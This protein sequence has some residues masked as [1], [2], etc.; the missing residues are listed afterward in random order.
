MVPFIGQIEIGESKR[1]LQRSEV[2]SRLETAIG[3][4]AV[5]DMITS[6]PVRFAKGVDHIEFARFTRT[7]ALNE[8]VVMHTRIRNS[9][10]LCGRLSI[11]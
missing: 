9:Q 10:G 11:R 5:E 8:G 7:Y 3:L 4:H 1:D 6:P 2:A